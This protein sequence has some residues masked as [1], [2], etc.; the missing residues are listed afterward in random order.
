LL[1][2]HSLTHLAHAH[3]HTTGG[4]TVITRSKEFLEAISKTH[5]TPGRQ[6]DLIVSNLEST[7]KEKVEILECMDLKQRLEKVLK[8]IQNHIEMLNVASKIN[9]SVEGS[10][11][12][13]RRE[14]YLRQQMKAIREELGEGAQEDTDDEGAQLQESLDKADLPEAAQKIADREMTRL[15]RMQ[16]AQPEYNVIRSYLELMAEL[17]WNKGTKDRLKPARVQKQ[18]DADHYGLEKVKERIVQYVAVRALKKD[19]KGPI[20]CLVGPPG[21][22]KTSL[23][24][25]IA[26]S[27]GREFARLA[28]GGV[29]DE[30]GR[31]PYMYICMYVCVCV[32]T[33]IYIYISI[34]LYIYVYVLCH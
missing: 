29:R 17:P 13:S 6:A 15:K 33:Y 8:L 19:V 24:K 28:L 18:L 4:N 26:A 34:Y 14:F 12:D 23:G 3:T 10:L 31:D 2:F 5:V 25:S 9:S 32:C 11:N 21:V 27:L 1:L 20:L 7:V 16:P 22:G 30:A